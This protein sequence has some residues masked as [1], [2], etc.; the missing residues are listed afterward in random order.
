M[1]HAKWYAARSN[2]VTKKSTLYFLSCPGAINL[3]NHT[4]I[5]RTLYISSFLFLK[6]DVA[7]PHCKQLDVQSSACFC[8]EEEDN[9]CLVV[10]CM[11][12]LYDMGNIC[13]EY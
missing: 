3:L 8:F 12:I 7:L 2:F 1:L 4:M 5:L 10:L 6:D 13:R 9:D 11:S